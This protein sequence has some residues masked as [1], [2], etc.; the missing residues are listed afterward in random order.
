[1]AVE[2]NKR[3]SRDY[4]DPDKRSI[5]N[6]VQVFFKSGGATERVEVEYPVG[7]RRRRAE[8]IPLLETKFERS[9]A[10]RLPGAQCERLL[11]LCRDQQRLESASVGEFVN[12][13]I[14]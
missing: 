3:F 11:D 4:L 5:G 14:F 1:M 7:H 8:G 12:L 9:I 6:A 2:E 13:W 10:T